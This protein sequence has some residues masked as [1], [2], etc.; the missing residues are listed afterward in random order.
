MKN[1][2]S[3][4]GHLWKELGL[5]QRVSLVLAAVAVI[6]ALTA[7]TLWSRRPDMQLLYG[8]ARKKA[9]LTQ[10]DA[11]AQKIQKRFEKQ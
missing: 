7:L 10:K 6:G 4:L 11:E 3:S 9:G 2:F 1:F 5:N 8:R